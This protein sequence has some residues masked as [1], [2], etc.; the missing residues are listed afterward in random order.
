MKTLHSIVSVLS[1]SLYQITQNDLSWWMS[2]LYYNTIQYMTNITTKQT[3]AGRPIHCWCQLLALKIRVDDELIKS[4]EITGYPTRRP[5]L[6]QKIRHNFNKRTYPF[7]SFGYICNYLI[8]ESHSV[9]WMSHFSEHS[10]LSGTVSV[11]HPKHHFQCGLLI[12]SG[13]RALSRFVLHCRIVF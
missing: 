6:L 12:R 7:D 2:S 5:T 9:R 4:C 8:L 3:D 1:L 10:W 11:E 13:W